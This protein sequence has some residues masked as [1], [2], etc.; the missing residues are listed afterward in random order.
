MSKKRKSESTLK[1]ND[2]VLVL[3]EDTPLVLTDD[4]IHDIKAAVKA[5]NGNRNI[6]EKYAGG[7]WDLSI[8]LTG[9]TGE[10]QEE[11]YN[12]LWDIYEK[13]SKLKEFAKGV[14]NLLQK[15]TTQI[16]CTNVHIVTNTFTE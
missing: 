8:E 1:I 10:F 2:K 5:V 9:T 11:V 14:E 12:Y 16:I 15:P 7:L 6:D 4:L 13:L 3:Q